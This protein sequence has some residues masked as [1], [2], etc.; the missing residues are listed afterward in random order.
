MINHRTGLVGCLFLIA[1]FAWFAVAVAET[2]AP[3][4]LRHDALNCGSCGNSCFTN[5]ENADWVC[6]LG[7][8]E[9]VGC[10]AGYYDLDGDGSCEYACEFRSSQE[11]CNGIDD[12]CDGVID[13]DAVVADIRATCGIPLSANASEC[14]SVS[15]DSLLSCSSTRL[16]GF[17]D[18]PLSDSSAS[19]NIVL[20]RDLP[21]FVCFRTF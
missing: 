3:L 4:E 2:C 9:F 6:N 15:G 10:R 5:T 17:S 18:L 8:C 21:V 16:E 19:I 13:E 7:S 12:D 14:T 11:A 20:P 1:T